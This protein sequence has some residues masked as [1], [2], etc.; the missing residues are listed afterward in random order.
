METVAQ[1]TALSAS[2]SLDGVTVT[3]PSL[4]L[5]L[6]ANIGGSQAPSPQR[7]RHQLISFHLLSPPYS[8]D[9]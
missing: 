9:I 7:R 8:N 5:C 1:L 4:P 2:Q 6:F 3:P